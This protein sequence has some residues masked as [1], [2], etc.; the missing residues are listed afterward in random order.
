[1]SQPQAVEKAGKNTVYHGYSTR[2]LRK[3]AE[4]RA[5]DKTE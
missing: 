5:R 2:V 4:K 3:E 1:M